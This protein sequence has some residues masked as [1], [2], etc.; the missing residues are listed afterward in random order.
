MRKVKRINADSFLKILQTVV[1]KGNIWRHWFVNALMLLCHIRR[2]LTMFIFQQEIA[3]RETKVLKIDLQDI[4]SVSTCLLY[5]PPFHHELFSHLHLKFISL[6]LKGK[7]LLL[8]SKGTRFD[9]LGILK[10]RQTA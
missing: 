4:V 1:E 7:T 10:P 5:S 6:T 8:I 9:I 2:L 3:N